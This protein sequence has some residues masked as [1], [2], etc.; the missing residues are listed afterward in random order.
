MQISIYQYLSWHGSYWHYLKIQWMWYYYLCFFKPHRILILS[1]SHSTLSFLSHFQF[2]SQF[3]FENVLINNDQI[4][5]NEFTLLLLGFFFWASSSCRNERNV[6]KIKTTKNL[7]QYI[8]WDRWQLL[9]I[10]FQEKA[11]YKPI[12]HFTYPLTKNIHK[13]ASAFLPITFFS[14][15]FITVWCFYIYM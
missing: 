11:K 5:E 13:A 6:I 8:V 1:L 12:A 9:Y 4:E 10:K 15:G 14:F 3:N 2:Q 7:I